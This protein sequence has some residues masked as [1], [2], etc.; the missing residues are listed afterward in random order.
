MHKYNYYKN[1]L[2]TIMDKNINRTLTICGSARFRELKEK[3]QAY[4]TIKNN[5]VFAPV[6]YLL[7]KNDVEIDQVTQN[8]NV[9][10]L[11][12]IHKTKINLSDAIIVVNPEGYYGEHTKKEILSAIKSDK[13]ILYTYVHE[14]KKDKYYFN[15]DETYPLYMLKEE[16]L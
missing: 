5:L 1:F 2:Q 12:R 15:N 13:F 3:Y 11:E 4:Y 9:L 14:S 10:Y 7:I 8:E 16:Y 6:N